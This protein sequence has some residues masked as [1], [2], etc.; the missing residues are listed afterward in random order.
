[1]PVNRSMSY[2]SPYPQGRP[3]QAPAGYAEDAWPEDSYQSQ[4]GY[5]GQPGYE[6]HPG[7]GASGAHPAYYGQQDHGQQDYGDG[8]DGSPGYG[9]YP[10]MS[11]YQGSGGYPAQVDPYAGAHDDFAASPW[12]RDGYP[13]PQAFQYAQATTSGPMPQA[14]SGPMAQAHS[15]PMPQ[16]PDRQSWAGLEQ[17][18]RPERRGV[19]TGAVMGLISAGLAI[20]VATF[21]AAFFRPNASPVIAVG[22]AFI[23][24]TPQWLK[25]FAIQKFGEH[26]KD[27]LLL[28]MYVTIAFLAMTIGVLARRR[29]SIGVVG[30]A[31]FGAFGAFVAYTRPASKASD[32]IPSLIGGVFGAIALLLLA[33]ASEPVPERVQRSHGGRR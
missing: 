16:A 19:L 13:Q 33:N 4:Q 20:G 7:Y 2:D 3:Y 27:M 23:D 21:V 15:G 14:Y 30:V 25:E 24:R 8:F 29:I 31:L 9:G 5:G 6:A 26:D 11:S 1:M 28:G 22:E 32:V 18:A 10:E 12:E 17:D